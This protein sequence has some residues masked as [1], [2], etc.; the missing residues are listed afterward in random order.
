ML[1]GVW[2][3][4]A[5]VR[6]TTYICQIHPVQTEHN[7]TV[8]RLNM[9]ISLS[10]SWKAPLLISCHL[11]TI[12]SPAKEWA[13]FFPEIIL[14]T[15]DRTQKINTPATQ[16]PPDWPC[17]QSVWETSATL[18]LASRYEL[19]IMRLVAISAGIGSFRACSSVYL[20]DSKS[21]ALQLSPTFWELHTSGQELWEALPCDVHFVFDCLCVNVMCELFFLPAWS[22]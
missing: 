21:W 6:S 10:D 5:S 17:H 18:T 3:R 14:K 16:K 13:I 11:S 8:S 4:N 22:C 12:S 7:S 1:L 9:I 15:Q 2:E 19:R 20:L